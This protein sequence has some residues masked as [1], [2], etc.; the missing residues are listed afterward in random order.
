METI[1]WQDCGRNNY[2]GCYIG[3]PFYVEA[4]AD[5]RFDLFIDETPHGDSFESAGHAFEYADNH[6]GDITMEV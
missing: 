6:L 2:G 1:K 5:G 4:N 3:G